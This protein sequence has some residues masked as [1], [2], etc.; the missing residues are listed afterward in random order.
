MLYRILILTLIWG[1]VGCTESEQS[2]LP[3]LI[4]LPDTYI[5]VSDNIVNL[6]QY[7]F[8]KGLDAIKLETEGIKYQ[9]DST[10]EVKGAYEIDVTTKGI[11]INA[12]DTSGIVNS[13][14]TLRQ[15]KDMSLNGLTPELHLTDSPQFEYRGMHLDVGR[16][17]F[18]VDDIK[19]YIDM[20]SYYKFNYF[21]W[22]LT[23]D[24]GWRIEIKR[25]PK[26]QSIAS[27]RDETLIGHYNDTPA[28]YDNTR[29][30]G[31]YTQ[32]EI[33]EI[34]TYATNLGIQ[35]IPEIE[36]PGHSLA[37]L[38]AYPELGC[39]S[40]NY[41]AATTWGVFPE[42]YCPREE[43]FAFLE[44]VLDEVISLFPCEYIHI[45]GDEA[46]KDAWKN[47]TFCQQ[48]IKRENLKDEHGLQSY[49][50][51]RMQ[52]YIN[53]KGKKIIGWDEILEGGLAPNATVMSWRGVEGG[54]AAAQANHDVIMTPTSHCY[55]DYYQ[56]ENVDEPLAIGGYLPLKKVYEWNPIPETL[57]VEKHKYIKGAQGNVWTEYIKSFSHV[58]Y[59]AYTR[60]MALAEVLWVEPEDKDYSH[61][62]DRYET[63]ATYWQHD[64]VNI[65][66]H[67]MDLKYQMRKNANAEIEIVF[68]K[69]PDL[70]K[71][72]C[73]TP[74][75]TTKLDAANLIMILD[76]AGDY[77]FHMEEG[78]REGKEIHLS[79]IDHLLFGADISLLHEPHNAYNG[80]GSL[81]LINGVK[82]NTEKY[83]GSE[84]LGFS[85]VPMDATIELD[86]KADIYSIELSTFNAIGQWIYPPKAIEVWV[87]HENSEKYDRVANNTIVCEDDNQIFTITTIINQQNITHLRIKLEDFGVIPAGAQGAGSRAW[88]FVDEI[89]VR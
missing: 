12:R 13:I 21:H 79:V 55:F 88:L 50:I 64:G 43:T 26:L 69:I 14:S 84:W 17:M 30:G 47:S 51:R 25:Y 39:E 85:G 62:I 2:Y 72:H 76:E 44:G 58:E 87:K 70:A 68:D 38:S 54:I 9:L 48:L 81:S 11:V 46:P 41:K 19:K 66:N 67:L 63:H 3:P 57:P 28:K 4:P 27:Y 20:I 29:Y 89:I 33:K 5:K 86:Q 59:M 42:I 83:S 80:Y 74:N 34:V 40:K 71:I 18:A 8:D 65:A 16:H 24:Q 36:M 53:S 49:F 35:I 6:N 73:V 22:H 37:A 32:A 23:E 75:G 56:S 15:L 77:V 7:F 45:G 31:Y 61:F 52:K 78:K 10:L 1:I 60:M 82:G